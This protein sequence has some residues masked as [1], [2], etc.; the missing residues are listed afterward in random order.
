MVKGKGGGGW[1]LGCKRTS[2]TKCMKTDCT[3]RLLGI[4]QGFGKKN[5]CMCS[6]AL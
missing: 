5:V 3:M 6:C 2:Y 4:G 1:F